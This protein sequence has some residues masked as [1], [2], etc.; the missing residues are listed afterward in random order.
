M[1]F[2][3]RGKGRFTGGAGVGLKQGGVFHA[4][5]SPIN[6][7][8]MQNGTIN[9]YFFEAPTSGRREG[10]GSYGSRVREAS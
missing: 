4:Q 7:R 8:R 9:L 6:A 1:T 2:H 3:Q 10:P 5:H